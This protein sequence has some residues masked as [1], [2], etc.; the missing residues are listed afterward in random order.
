M[1]LRWRSVVLG[2]A[3]WVALAGLIGCSRTTG[4]P[5][6][7]HKIACDRGKAASCALLAEMYE[8][9]KDVDKNLARAA[10][11]YQRA[12]EG[13]N[14]RGCA[15]LG[16]MYAEGQGQTDSQMKRTKNAIV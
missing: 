16:V 4:A 11:L 9:G 10:Q 14:G 8:E 5:A 3:G 2:G 13:G 6:A 7:Q 12:C 15:S 1:M